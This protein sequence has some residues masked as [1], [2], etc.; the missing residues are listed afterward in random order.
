MLVHGITCSGGF[1]GVSLVSMETPFQIGIK[2]LFT[3]M[4]QSTT[5]VKNIL[6]TA[7]HPVFINLR[8]LL[9]TKGEQVV[10][11]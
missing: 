5:V 11:N 10:L 3:I 8:V 2:K 7:V 6:C 4:H 9:T 1:R